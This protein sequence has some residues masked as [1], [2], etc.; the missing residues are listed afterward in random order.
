M[1]CVEE[2]SPVIERELTYLCGKHGLSGNFRGKITG[3]MAVAGENS[4]GGVVE[5]I[6]SFMR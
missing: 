5:A 4:N 3:D 2:L 1:L 6:A